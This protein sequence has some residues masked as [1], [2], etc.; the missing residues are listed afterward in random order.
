[1]KRGLPITA[2]LAGHRFSQAVDQKYRFGARGS[3]AIGIAAES[4][5]IH[6]LK[7]RQCGDAALACDFGTR[8][9]I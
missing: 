7:K 5:M 9:L 3:V 6:C 2:W 1:M 4:Q 8:F